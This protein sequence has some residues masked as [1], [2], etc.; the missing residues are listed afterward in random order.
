M[1][2]FEERDGWRYTA[3]VTNTQVG[4]LQWLQACHRARVEDLIGCAKTPAPRRLPPRAKQLTAAF[5][6]IAAIPAPG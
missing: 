4:A 2:L 1:S 5:N 3:F 6:Q